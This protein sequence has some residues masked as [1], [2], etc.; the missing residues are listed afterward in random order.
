[1]KGASCGSVNLLHTR[2]LGRK[3]RKLLFAQEAKFGF[4]SGFETR[5]N[6]GKNRKEAKAASG[7]PR[8]RRNERIDPVLRRVVTFRRKSRENAK[9]REAEYGLF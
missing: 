9:A 7:E 1:V 8:R 4:F 3:H 2:F 6:K 5:S